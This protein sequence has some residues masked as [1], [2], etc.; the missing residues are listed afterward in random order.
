[1][2][3]AENP[4]GP[5]P[6]DGD[7]HEGANVDK[8]RDILFGSQM[9]DYDKRF[10]RLEER[11]SRDA[12]ALREELKKRLDTLEAFVQQEVESLS[13]RLKNEKTER[14]DGVKDLDRELRESTK[15]LDKKIGHVDDELAKG[16]VELR[17]RILEQSKAL[18][19][20]IESKHREMSA[21][22]DREVQVLQ[23]DKTDRKALADLFTELAL[24]LKEEFELPEGK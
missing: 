9:R 22:L 5:V 15:S 6:A 13:Q 21:S 7:I 14:T 12:A 19:T 11:L 8:I 4:N 3:S 1:M 24:R 17:A 20:E 2:K 18:M 10:A 23:T 16:T